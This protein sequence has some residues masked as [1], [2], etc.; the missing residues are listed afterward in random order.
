MKTPK[1]VR[2]P[3]GNWRIQLYMDGKRYSFTDPDLKVVKQKAKEAYA[4]AQL[5]KRS[6]LTVGKAIDKYIESKTGVLSPSTIMVYKRYRRNYLQC[7]MDLN[8]TD[9]KQEHVQIAVSEDAAEG[10]SPKTIRNAHGMLSAV[11]K[12]YRPKLVLRTT[13]PQKQKY[14]VRIPTEEEMKKIWTSAKGSRYELPILLA[15]WLGLRMSEIRGLKYSDFQDG[16]VHIQRAVVRGEGGSKIK[17]TKTTSGDRW[18]KCPDEILN[19]VNK[20][21]RKDD[22]LCNYYDTTLYSGFIS[23][24]KK[25]GIEPCR[26]HDLRHF[27]ASEAHS[28]GVPDKY[29]MQR[30]G[31]KTDNMLKMVYQH[32]MRDKEELFAD[33]IDSHMSKLFSAPIAHEIAH[34]S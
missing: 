5:E 34:D 20:Q 14:Q 33:L 25:A 6:S 27:A 24:C 13:L 26:F 12:T 31:H 16:Y 8:I 18:I 2:L 1:A 11:L 29:Q 23:I 30:M 28:L 7:L 3:S 21:P 15:S 32:T 19:M 9:L 17:T 22:F 4:G 10:L